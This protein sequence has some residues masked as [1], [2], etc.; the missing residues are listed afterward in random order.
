MTAN[1]VD[2]PVTAQ[3]LQQLN[4]AIRIISVSLLEH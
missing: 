2:A 3:G 4:Y 1:T